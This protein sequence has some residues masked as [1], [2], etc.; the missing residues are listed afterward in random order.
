MSQT[1]VAFDLETT[2][3]DPKKD[4]IIEIAMVRF[5]ADGNTLAEFSSLVHP[6]MA[7]P[8]E[9][10][11]ITGITDA[12]VETAPAFG[13][14]RAEVAAF[15]G[16][17]AVV[18]HNADFD[19]AFLRE[20]GFDFST[21]PVV[22]TFRLAQLAF[23]E[24]RSMNLSNL[25]EVSGYFHE[26]AHRALSDA[27]AT[28][29]LF[30]ECLRRIRSAHPALSLASRFLAGTCPPGTTF[31]V[32]VSAAS[33]SVV[34]PARPQELFESVLA[35]IPEYSEIPAVAAPERF[36]T[37]SETFS[38]DGSL[39]TRPEQL[40]MAEAVAGAFEGKRLLAIEAPTGIGKTF[41]YMLP[42]AVASVRDGTR[43]VVSTNTKTLQDQ[44]EHKDVPKIRTMLAPF[45]LS[46][47]RFAKLKGRNNYASL[48]KLSEFA[49]RESFSEEEALFFSRAC[50]HVSRVRSGELDDLPLY[51]KQ[52]ELVSDIHSGDFRVLSPENPY[53]KKEPLYRAREAVKTAD[54]ALVNHSLLL[55]E[56]ADDSVGTVGKIERLVVDEAHNLEAAATDALSRALA[57]PDVERTF[58]RIE[59]AVRRHNRQPAA[60]RFPFPEL[61]E[62]ANSFALTYGM[63][64]ELA[65]RY[66][67][68][69]S[70]NPG[71]R[72]E[73]GKGRPT[74]AL[75]TEDFFSSESAAS[76]SGIVT[77][78]Y[79]KTKDLSDRLKGAPE[80]LLEALASPL[81]DLSFFA[82]FLEEFLAPS[83][84]DLIKV[85]SVR[86]GEGARLKT[87]P[88]DV[89]NPL[90][91]KLWSRVPA[92]V[93]TSAT[94]TVGEDFSF[95]KRSLGLEG[96]EF[97]ILQSDFDYSKQAT[98]F[99][100]T[101]LGDVRNE[102][103]R[104]KVHAFIRDA[105]LAAGGRVMAL[106][107]SFS[108]I[109][110][111]H[112]QIQSD[113]RKAGIKLLTQGLSGGKHK[114]VEEFK[115]GSDRSALF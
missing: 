15:F 59:T 58:A 17:S 109:R 113:L 40:K 6:G 43:I 88:L 20:C 111:A 45:G 94:L 36:P 103:E 51:G 56:I 1:F 29:F 41:A 97:R 71:F 100:P 86:P 16:D 63:V 33:E 68:G 78:A 55:T 19:T 26:G 106:F 2:G 81:S 105:I 22:D 44:I 3:L 35:E 75:V 67:L 49:D 34:L 10:S 115:R 102:S 91:D 89:S 95:L 7:I 80:K 79:E 93:L 31:P 11:S 96:F 50:L 82:S 61:R 60:E 18:A 70:P 83:R 27:R 104:S 69:K 101:D 28:V 62:I 46:D 13:D 8:E 12:D 76:M 114:M 87:L 38:G 112:L 23:P 77:A 92:A 30:R 66:A 99:L 14:I 52:Y 39:E 98:V 54:I 53:R 48:L 37:V 84:T 25:A 90:R 4:A 21:A 9:A 108:A 72:P 42:A 57:L 107:T 24:E 5:D 74:E 73:Y 32:A 110:E 85:V 47:F 65:E 64:L